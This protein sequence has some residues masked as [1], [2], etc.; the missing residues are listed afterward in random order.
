MTGEIREDLLHFARTGLFDRIVGENGGTLLGPPDRE[1]RL[2]GPELPDEFVRAAV[3]R[4]RPLCVGR[5]LM[6]TRANNA[7]QLRR[8]VSP[9]YQLI[10]NGKDVMALPAGIT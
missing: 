8:A 3:G 7:D 6:G 5:V 4:C 10:E 1:C 9:D 2:L